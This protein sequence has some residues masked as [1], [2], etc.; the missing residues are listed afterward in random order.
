VLPVAAA[1]L[2]AG[3]LGLPPA[4]QAAGRDTAKLSTLTAADSAGK[5]VINPIHPGETVAIGLGARNKGDAAVD[6]LVVSLRV[7]DDLYLP[8]EFSNCEYYE[9]G[10]MHG[11]WCQIDGQL[12]AGASSGIT[13]FHVSAL[14]NASKIRGGMMI[15]TYS[16]AW[17]DTQGGIEALA[18]SAAVTGGPAAGAGG[19]LELGAAA[20]APAKDWGPVGFSYYNL[21]SA[22]PS[23]SSSSS[24]GT[25]TGTGTGAGT[26][27]ASP[28]ASATSSSPAAA[29]TGQHNDGGGLPITG[30][31]TVI[32]IGAGVLL[33]GGGAVAFAVARR[34]RAKFVA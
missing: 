34:R 10:A 1:V 5:S 9:D 20:P 18:K 33:L 6:G 26:G 30:S 12:A 29:A 2:T 16:K 24:T 11:A 19:K 8:K 28:S 27:T 4:A 3:V 7:Q 21:I 14:K 13:P 32:A 23:G 25:G 17:A 22:S 31:D 15:A